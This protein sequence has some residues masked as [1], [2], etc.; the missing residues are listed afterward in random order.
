LTETEVSQTNT[1]QD[2]FCL[3][4]KTRVTAKTNNECTDVKTPKRNVQLQKT[5]HKMPS[6]QAPTEWKIHAIDSWH[7]V[8]Q[9]SKCNTYKNGLYCAQ[10]E[11]R[12]LQKN[13]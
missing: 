8:T 11:D 5:E 9:L 6:F 1:A 10:R 13:T 2:V 3:N 12:T 7:A 4:K